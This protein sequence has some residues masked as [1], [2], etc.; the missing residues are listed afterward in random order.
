MVEFV[1]PFTS[2]ETFIFLNPR[3]DDRKKKRI[4][5]AIAKMPLKNHIWVSSS[6]TEQHWNKI[7]MVALS[8]ESFLIA[9]RGV[10]AVF[11]LSSQDIYLNVLPLFHVGGLSILARC[12]LTGCHYDSLLVDTKWNVENFV[13]E[14]RKRFI[15]VTSLVPTQVFDIVAGN[16]F[17]PESLRFVFVGGG[18]LSPEL[19]RRAE[20][21][22]WHCVATY[23]M[24][25]TAAMIAYRE[26]DQEYQLFPHIE[27]CRTAETQH[28]QIKSP[29]LFTGYLYVDDEGNYEYA[30]PKVEGWFLSDDRAIVVN[31]TL[32]ILGRESE[33]V[34]INGE[35]VSIAQLN[36]T[37]EN[38][39]FQKHISMESVIIA[40]E[41]SRKGYQL[42]LCV[43]GDLPQNHVDTFN[44]TV[45]PFERITIVKKFLQLPRTPLGKLDI[46]KLRKLT[47]NP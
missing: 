42:V 28:L 20:E 26:K 21:L 44:Q 34:K 23:G 17:A 35:S 12:L 29:A 27:E 2:D 13:K 37:F 33:L 32:Q 46:S 43:E 36:I 8:K 22:G 24:T 7:K 19:Q 14:V 5:H 4:E 16:L 41:D 38:F 11:P 6:G 31:R 30:D 10:S 40:I 18:R 15:T 25:E 1:N 45:L 47:V 3:L 9:A 39:S